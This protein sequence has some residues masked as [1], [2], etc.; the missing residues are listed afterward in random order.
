VLALASK[1]IHHEDE[2]MSKDEERKVLESEL[3][4][5][6]LFVCNSPLKDDTLK[7]IQNLQRAAYKLLMITGDNLF[8]A[9]TVGQQLNFGKE[10]LTVEKK[11]DKIVVEVDKQNHV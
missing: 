8:T 7:S 4:F 1:V 9:A 10:I 3:N 5:V 6:G 2:T 11:G